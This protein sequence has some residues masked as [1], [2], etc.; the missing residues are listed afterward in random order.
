MSTDSLQFLSC[1]VKLGVFYGISMNV[2]VCRNK[3]NYFVWS[4]YI[5]TRIVCQQRF[6][7]YGHEEM[8]SDSP[9]HASLRLASVQYSDLY[10]YF[11]Y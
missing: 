10:E 9:E 2:L 1:F 8:R 5:L 7:N 11:F 3:A 4:S 6:R